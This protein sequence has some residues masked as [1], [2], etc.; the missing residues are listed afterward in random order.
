MEIT[1][2]SNVILYYFEHSELLM[3]LNNPLIS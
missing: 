1:L 2:I 3:N